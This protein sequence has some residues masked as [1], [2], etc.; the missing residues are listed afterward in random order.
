MDIG[1]HLFEISHCSLLYLIF[2]NVTL[3]TELWQRKHCDGEENFLRQGYSSYKV[4]CFLVCVECLVD[5]ILDLLCQQIG[6]DRACVWP[7]G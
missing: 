2:T 3:T 1:K 7:M 6:C 5:V 4:L